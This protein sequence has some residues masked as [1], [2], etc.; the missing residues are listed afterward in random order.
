M[1]VPFPVSTPRKPDAGHMENKFGGR[2]MT[3]AMYKIVKG[4]G[5]IKDASIMAKGKETDISGL[6][7]YETKQLHGQ[8]GIFRCV[9]G[10][11]TGW[12]YPDVPEEPVYPAVLEEV[13]RKIQ[14]MLKD[15]CTAIVKEYTS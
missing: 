11:S 13:N 2:E 14:E 3:K 4:G 12:V 5:R 15:F 6:T 10:K 7:K 8:Y 9:S 1:I